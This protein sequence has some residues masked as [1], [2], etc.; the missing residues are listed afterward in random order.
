MVIRSQDWNSRQKIADNKKLLL[1]F[2]HLSS[3]CRR[4]QLRQSFFFLLQP[5][6]RLIIALIIIAIISKL[7]K[8]KPGQFCISP[9]QFCSNRVQTV[10]HLPPWKRAQSTCTSP[11]ESI[12]VPL[13]AQ[14]KTNVQLQLITTGYRCGYAIHIKCMDVD[15]RA[16]RSSEHQM[17]FIACSALMTG[18]LVQPHEH[19]TKPNVV[20]CVNGI[21]STVY[22]I[23]LTIKEKK[24]NEMR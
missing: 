4:R 6:T 15:Q 13:R 21:W 2:K 8:T 10:R 7:P 3:G 12:F 20:C 5:S 23:V 22:C 11:L 19:R 9:L 17:R 24:R 18:L 14:I 16:D 1:Q